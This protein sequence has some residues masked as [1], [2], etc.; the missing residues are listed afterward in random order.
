MNAMEAVSITNLIGGWNKASFHRKFRY[1]STEVDATFGDFL[2]H[3]T[4]KSDGLVLVGACSVIFDLWKE[5]PIFIKN[6]IFYIFNWYDT[7]LERIQG[8]QHNIANL[9]GCVNGF[10]SKLKL[11]KTSLENYEFSFELQRTLRWKFSKDATFLTTWNS[12]TS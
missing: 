4:Q 12:S 7:S 6:Q 5:S 2:L 3:Y 1:F 11:F 9:Y 10:R 8:K